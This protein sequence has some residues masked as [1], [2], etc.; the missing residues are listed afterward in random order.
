M[1]RF[2]VDALYNRRSGD[3]RRKTRA[4]DKRDQQRA[5]YGTEKGRREQTVNTTIVLRNIIIALNV[6]C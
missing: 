2:Y 1:P 3:D 6:R 5:G 4:G